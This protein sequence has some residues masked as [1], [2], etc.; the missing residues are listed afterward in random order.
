MVFSVSKFAFFSGSDPSGA[1]NPNK[2]G[3]FSTFFCFFSGLLRILSASVLNSSSPKIRRSSVSS[4]SATLSASMSSSTGTSVRMVARKRDM[5]MSSTCSVTFFCKA[6]FI[7]SVRRSI[8]S[9]LPNW[10]S[11]FTAVFSPTPGQPGKLSAESP[12]NASRSITWSVDC[13]PYL[14]VTSLAPMVS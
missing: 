10:V 5:R 9:M 6:P 11:S 2:S 7:S 13:S 8:S 3:C 4:G 12:I 14:A 1:K